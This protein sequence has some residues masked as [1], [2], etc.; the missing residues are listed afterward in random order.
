MSHLIRQVCSVQIIITSNCFYSLKITLGNVYIAD[1]FNN[2]IRKVTAS[3]GFITTIAGTGNTIYSGDNGPA[4]SAT[5]NWPSAL[6][7]DSLG[8]S[9]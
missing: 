6:D 4:T 7:L 9:I 3:T 5:L 1:Y 2:R 8:L